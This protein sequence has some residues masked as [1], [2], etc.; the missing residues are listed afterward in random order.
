MVATIQVERAEY[1]DGYR[2]RLWFD[3]GSIQDV[4]FAGPFGRLKG[5]YARYRQPEY[6]RQFRVD[7]GNVVWGQDWDVIFPVWKLYTNSLT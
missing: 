5:Y 6:F 4:D 1:L 3:D 2:L 7:E